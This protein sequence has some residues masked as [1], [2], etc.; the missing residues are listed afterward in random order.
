MIGL[1]QKQAQIQ[2]IVERQIQLAPV[3]YVDEIVVYT[4]EQDLIDLLLT[5]PIDVRV[6]GEEYK[7]KDSLAK[8]LLNKEAV[9]L[10][11]MAE[12]LVLAV[13]KFKKT[14]STRRK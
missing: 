8:I 3:K 14:C 7:N 12:T 1:I 5:L 11:T 9:K 13:P 4:P 2:T 10:F 6:L